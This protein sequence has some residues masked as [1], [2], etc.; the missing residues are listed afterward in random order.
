MRQCKQVRNN[1]KNLSAK[2]IGK[3]SE[4]EA[5]NYLQKR[6]L[7]LKYRNYN[8]KTGEIDLIMEDDGVLVFVEVR[9]RKQSKY[10]SSLES[11]TKCKQQKVIRAAKCYLLENDLFDKMQ[12]RFDIVAT[13]LQDDNK[14]LWIKDAFWEKF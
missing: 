4:N 10:G 6:G 1:A 12:C 13:S 11:V 2:S 14:I 9:Y 3:Q 5:A 7:K 8:C